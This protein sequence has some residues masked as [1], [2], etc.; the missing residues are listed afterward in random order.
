MDLL[1]VSAGGAE[2]FFKIPLGGAFTTDFCEWVELLVEEEDVEGTLN[3]LALIPSPFLVT[4]RDHFGS[5]S[6]SL[7]ELLDPDLGVDFEDLETVLKLVPEDDACLD[8]DEPPEGVFVGFEE[9]LWGVVDLKVP[10]PK[11]SEELDL[12]ERVLEGVLEA[13]GEKEEGGEWTAVGV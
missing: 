8:L 9:E 5:F 10:K 12:L 7:K 2:G 3:F 13:L 1:K 6:L 4:L 11:I